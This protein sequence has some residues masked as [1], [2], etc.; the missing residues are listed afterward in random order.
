MALKEEIAEFI[1]SRRLELNLTMEELAI[2]VYD[3]PKMKSQIA[4]PFTF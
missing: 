4:I 3:N 1:R 2:L